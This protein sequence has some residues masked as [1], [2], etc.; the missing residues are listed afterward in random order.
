MQYFPYHTKVLVWLAS[1]LEPQVKRWPVSTPAQRQRAHDRSVFGVSCQVCTTPHPRLP[2]PMRSACKGREPCCG[3]LQHLM[4]AAQLDVRLFVRAS[5]NRQRAMHLKAF[6]STASG[7]LQ[8]WVME[9][10]MAISGAPWRAAS[11]TITTVAP[12]TAPAHV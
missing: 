2:Q 4:D 8:I 12:L 5:G 3:L 11:C 6:C 9:Q 1:G 7:N 10:G